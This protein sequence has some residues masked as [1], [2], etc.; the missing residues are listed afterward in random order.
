[1]KNNNTNQRNNNN[2]NSSNTSYHY[3]DKRKPHLAQQQ[4]HQ[5]HA[6]HPYQNQRERSGQRNQGGQYPD[7]SV[8]RDS[9]NNQNA[10][11]P[12][13]LGSIR[14]S[15]GFPTHELPPID[16]KSEANKKFTG[17]CRLFVGNLP[18]NTSEE[19]LRSLFEAHGEVGELY[20]GP[21]S[22]FAFIKMDTRQN[23]EAARNALDCTNY[24]NRTLRVRLAAHSAA[25]RIKYLSPQVTNELLAYAF[26][27]FGEIERAVIVVDDKGKSTGEGV[28]EFSKKQSALYAIKRCQQE[29]FMLTASPKPVQVEPYDQQDEEEG[30]PE[31]SINK[32]SK[33]FMEEREVG[34]RFAEQGSFEHS[35]ALK[36]KDLYEVEKKQRDK[37][38]Q[39]IQ[40]AR[41][42]LQDQIKYIRIEHDTMQLR[43]R[44]QQLE[45]DRMKLQ[46]M[47]E[48]TVV[49]SQMRDEQ[50]RQQ[51]MMNRQREDDMLRRQPQSSNGISD[52]EAA[53]RMQ[54]DALQNLLMSQEQSIVNEDPSVDS[55]QHQRPQQAQTSQSG[56]ELDSN[57]QM[58]QMNT[59]TSQLSNQPRTF[60]DVTM[61]G[62]NPPFLPVPVQTAM[63]MHSAPNQPNMFTSFVPAQMQMPMDPSLQQNYPVNTPMGG[64]QM[65]SQQPQVSGSNDMSQ[66][67][68]PQ[69]YNNNNRQYN[70]NNNSGG[71]NNNQSQY[72]NGNRPRKRGR[73]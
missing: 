22:A 67:R 23:A 49:N 3:N 4:S 40:D 60:A 13:N 15:P 28:V 6:S 64:Y 56:N 29:C 35:F 57:A 71:N 24:E 5:H 72:N 62:L 14:F 38:E 19:K 47:K 59:V 48:Q 18:H 31:K 73:F 1:M 21:K 17:R 52:Q 9:Y 46:Q 39:D 37:L 36:W 26:R 42:N 50:T 10:P 65:M 41:K 70:N 30:L 8:G 55:S 61:M 12:T 20:L 45:D 25:I 58:N 51:D 33:E 68:R 43:N 7:S 27:Y 54:G 53:L 66:M 44:L 34:P 63:N 32:H 16:A 69:Q 11:N 2:N